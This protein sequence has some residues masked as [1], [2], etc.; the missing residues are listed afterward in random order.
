LKVKEV[1][2]DESKLK[3]AE[4]LGA[5]FTV[6]S[7]KEN[8][9]IKLKEFTNDE[10]PD[11]IIEAA[12]QTST[13]LAA[14]ESVAFTGRVA[15]IGY[16]KE[17]VAFAT[18][19]FVQKEIDIIG[20]RNADSEDFKEVIDYLSR[21]KLPV[22]ELLSMIIKPEASFDAMKTWAANPGTVFKILVDFE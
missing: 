18:K 1:D 8:L 10:G 22:E 6:N 7:L 20:S 12:G 14:I 17:D 11:V 3:L 13:Y 16:A 19:L 9:P 21:G 15:C 5:V 4:K 2:V